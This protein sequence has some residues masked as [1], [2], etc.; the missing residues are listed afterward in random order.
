MNVIIKVMNITWGSNV[1][2][3]EVV[4][5]SHERGRG[6]GKGGTGGEVEVGNR[7]Q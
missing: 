4:T 2:M 1:V 7:K 5:L 3:R 6:T